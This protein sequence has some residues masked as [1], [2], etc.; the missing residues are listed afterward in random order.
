MFL[1]VN[2]KLFKVPDEELYVHYITNVTE[3][4]WISQRKTCLFTLS[5]CICSMKINIQFDDFIQN[6]HLFELAG[7]YLY[8]LY[9]NK[10]TP[11]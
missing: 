2:T 10:H 6:T 8:V 11:L 9:V 4:F 5:T 7:E 3:L 1:Q